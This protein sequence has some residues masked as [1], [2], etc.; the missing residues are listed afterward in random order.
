MRTVRITVNVPDSTAPAVL[1]NLNERA[2]DEGRLGLQFHPDVQF[3]VDV[4][5]CEVIA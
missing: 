2:V 4:L 3:Y 5:D 1:V